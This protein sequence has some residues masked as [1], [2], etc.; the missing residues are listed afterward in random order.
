[1]PPRLVFAANRH[2][3]LLALEGNNDANYGLP[4]ADFSRETARGLSWMPRD[5]VG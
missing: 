3:L 5:F 4:T 1:V 2:H